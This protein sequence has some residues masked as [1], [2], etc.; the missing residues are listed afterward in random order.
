MAY[1]REL[2]RNMPLYAQFADELGIGLLQHFCEAIQPH[3]DLVFNRLDQRDYFLDPEVAS[4]E[5]LNWLQQLVSLGPQGDRWLGLA[6]NPDWDLDAKRRLILGAWEYW[7]RKGTESGIRWAIEHWLLWDGATSPQLLR[8]FQPLGDRPINQPPRWWD[9][10]SSF[11]TN[12]DRLILEQKFLGGGDGPA[13]GRDRWVRWTANDAIAQWD[14][15]AS[16]L[17]INQPWI[18]QQSPTPR[19]LAG[20]CMGPRNVWQILTFRDQQ[21]WLAVAPNIYELNPEILPAYA[22][23]TVWLWLERDLSSDPW[24]LPPAPGS[25]GDPPPT[26]SYHFEPDGFKFT[27]TFPYDPR[28]AG[29]RSITVDVLESWGGEDLYFDHFESVGGPGRWVSQLPIAQPPIVDPGIAAPFDHLSEFAGVI[30]LPQPDLITI[31]PGMNHRDHFDGF[32]VSFGCPD[33]TLSVAQ[34]STSITVGAGRSLYAPPTD[35]PQDPIIVEPQWQPAIAARSFYCPPTERLVPREYWVDQLG[36]PCHRGM[37][38]EI[39]TGETITEVIPGQPPTPP[40]QWVD[41]QPAQ[42]EVTEIPVIAPNRGFDHFSW[43][44]VTEPIASI[45]AITPINPLPALDSTTTV[46]SQ[47]PLLDPIDPLLPISPIAIAGPVY[48]AQLI[49]IAPDDFLYYPGQSATEVITEIPA[50][51]RWESPVQI[52]THFTSWDEGASLYGPGDTGTPDQVIDRPITETAH[53]CNIRDNWTMFEV[54]REWWQPIAPPETARDM[55]ARYPD[56]ASVLDG[57]A[58]RLILETDRGLI[59]IPLSATVWE[60][61]TG[62]RSDRYQP[63]VGFDRLVLEFTFTPDQLLRGRSLSLV[64]NGNL[65]DRLDLRNLDLRPAGIF[66]WRYRYPI[67]LSVSILR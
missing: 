10:Y 54:E 53:L 30:A 40:N 61:A 37:A 46:N 20:Q 8:L 12:N 3:L 63:R 33:R 6:I 39:P 66:G 48:D 62:D 55:I 59:D 19:W 56:L 21:E 42:L 1:P 18:T 38:V 25:D 58:W 60:N 22:K 16:F 64:N 26:L 65:H 31:I 17:A 27:D 5:W 28:S 47:I 23:P 2:W 41:H 32:E 36:E 44:P 9:F 51:W 43:L 52:F 13:W 34:P 24:M 49:A 57:A 15:C 11:D 67:K 45:P 14:H 4:H 50:R 35:L 7:Q 29:Q